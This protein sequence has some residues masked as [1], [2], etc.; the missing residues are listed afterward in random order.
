MKKILSYSVA[1]PTATVNLTNIDTAGDYKTLIVYWKISETNNS[2]SPGSLNIGL[3]H[4]GS[5]NHYTTARYVT[6][7]NGSVI[8]VS[9]NSDSIS[10]PFAFP[11]AS[12]TYEFGVGRMI[13]NGRI[14]GRQARVTG[15]YAAPYGNNFVYQG[16]MPTSGLFRGYTSQSSLIT[17]I[18]FNCFYN[19]SAGTTFEIYGVK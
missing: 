15:R 17:S 6:G 19:F 14:S 18:R 16:D 4:N 9:S 7:G 10:V 13:I 2:S 5:L 1:S 11:G 3:N 8:G 12:W